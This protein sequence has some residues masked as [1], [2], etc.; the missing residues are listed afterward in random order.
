MQDQ[1]AVI[2]GFMYAGSAFSLSAN[3]H[4]TNG[5]KKKIAYFSCQVAIPLLSYSILTIFV[6]EQLLV[7]NSLYSLE[8]S[9]K[10]HNAIHLRDIYIDFIIIY[11]VPCG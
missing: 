2:N 6:Y 1:N 5:M 3:L 9:V 8:E 11:S 7:D 10:E 4:F